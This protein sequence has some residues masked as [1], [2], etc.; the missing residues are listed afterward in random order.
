MN[1]NT[2]RLKLNMY[3]GVIFAPQSALFLLFFLFSSF[4]CFFRKETHSLRYADVEKKRKE[5][6]KSRIDLQEEEEEKG[7]VLM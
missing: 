1:W 2:T 6:G 4:C 3:D 7:R 5:K